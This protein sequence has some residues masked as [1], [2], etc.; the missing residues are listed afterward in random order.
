MSNLG[1]YQVMTTVSKKVSGPV[2][3]AL[4]VAGA[5]YVVL[6]PIE[7]LSKKT[8]KM[9]KNKMQK[10][11]SNIK[12]STVFTVSNDPEDA[13]GLKFKSGDKYRIIETDGDAALIEI[14]ENDNNPYFV[15][16]EFLKTISKIDDFKGV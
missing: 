11:A 16:Y 6:R 8:F 13:S 1:W 10:N 3:L 15:S 7:S 12:S 9:V 14:L 4:L 5:G 2:K